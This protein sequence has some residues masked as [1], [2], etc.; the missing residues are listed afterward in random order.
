MLK[1]INF[2]L[3]YGIVI[4]GQSIEN[5]S[6]LNY[7]DFTVKLFP[8]ILQDLIK[9][10]KLQSKFHLTSTVSVNNMVLHDSNGQLKRYA[11]VD[12]ILTE[13]YNYRLEKYIIR[14]QYHIDYLTNEMELLE[15]QM[16]FIKLKVDG[17]VIIENRKRDAIIEE[18]RKK[19]K[20]PLLSRDP[21][22]DEKS[23]GF[24]YITN[25]SL[26]SLTT[27]RIEELQKKLDD[28]RNELTVYRETSIETIWEEELN[29]LEEEYNK[30]IKYRDTE[31]DDEDA[32]LATLKGKGKGKKKG[33]SNGKKKITIDV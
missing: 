15:Q 22:S 16:R 27:D 32:I 17:K 4:R 18:L 12:E 31:F 7:V 5:N 11:N 1:A 30:Y 29:V 21:H 25:L 13:Y 28:K 19:W 6:G 33:K 23:K 2:L 26:F 24:E 3:R 20:F 14:K 8:G 10:D 9:Q